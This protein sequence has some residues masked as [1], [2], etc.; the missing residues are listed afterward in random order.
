[1]TSTHN[2]HELV[3]VYSIQPHSVPSNQMERTL[4]TANRKCLYTV[5]VD[6][7]ESGKNRAIVDI[8]SLCY[9][10]RKSDYL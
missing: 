4:N 5:S 6:N 10:M 9:K 2:V 3:L 8:G 7:C 1:M